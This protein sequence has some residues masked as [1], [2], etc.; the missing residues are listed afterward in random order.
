M[1]YETEIVGRGDVLRSV[2]KCKSRSTNVTEDA[3]YERM[4]YRHGCMRAR[5]YT[6][7]VIYRRG[8]PRTGSYVETTVVGCTAT[9]GTAAAVTATVSWPVTDDSY[10][11]DITI[12]ECVRLPLCLSLYARTVR[13]PVL[14]VLLSIPVS[15]NQPVSLSLYCDVTLPERIPRLK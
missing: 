14:P 11:V 5:A 2:V 10:A 7:R 12:M 13:A 8:W 15:Y 6:R 4:E 3:S 9:T 1:T